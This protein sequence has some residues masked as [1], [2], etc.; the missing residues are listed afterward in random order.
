MVEKTLDNYSLYI[1]DFVNDI[2]NGSKFEGSLGPVEDFTFVDYWTLRKRSLRLFK[3]NL[4]AKGIIRR[5]LWNEIHTGLVAAPVPIGS[6]IWPKLEES[7]QEKKA[8]EYAEIFATEFNLYA[9]TPAIFDW[10]KKQSFGAFQRQVRFESLICGDGIIISRI[11]DK[12]G[13]P[14]WQWVNGDNIRTPDDYTPRNGN[15]IKHGVEFDKYGKKTAFHVRTETNGNV[16]YERVRVRGE[17]SGRLISWMVYGSETLLDDTRGEP[18]LADTLYMLKDLDRYR[19][20]ETRAAVINAMLAFFVERSQDT[21]KG[22]RPSDG[23]A[24]LRPTVGSEPAAEPKDY[25]PIPGKQLG[26]DLRMMK[27]GTF[28]DD[29]DPGQKIVSPATNRPNVN[30][31][32]FEEAII[33]ALAWTHGIPPEILMLKFGNNYSASRQANNEFEIYLSKQVEENANAFCRNIYTSFITQAILTG[34]LTAPG[35]LNAYGNKDKW[36]IESAWLQTAWL[37]L[38]RPSV[39]R[40]KEIRA[41]QLAVDNG[42]STFDKEALRNSGMTFKQVMQT[43]KR[44]R[45][46]M[47]RMGFVPKVD[48]DQ[49]GKPVYTESDIDSEAINDESNLNGNATPASTGSTS[50]SGV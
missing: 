2:W 35:F 18:F 8:A 19:D 26:E 6:V 40:E 28:F 30:Y 12:T 4:Y 38:S 50:G 22:A 34:M 29:L 11:D 15:Y 7:E 44:E 21:G 47:A 1:S 32:I 48:E 49:N 41:S 27:P 16:K 5:L 36:R 25:N 9:S 10:G 24:R 17:K 43:Q 42:F 13:L 20:A 39:D 14:R 46:Y 3:E 31:R 45:E 37:G 23:L 33:S